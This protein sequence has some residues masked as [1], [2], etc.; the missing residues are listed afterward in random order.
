MVIQMIL[1]T[2]SVITCMLFLAVGPAA[3]FPKIFGVDGE[4]EQGQVLVLDARGLADLPTLRVFITDHAVYSQASH[5]VE[6]VVLSRGG[7]SGPINIRA[8]FTGF[9]EGQTVYAIPSN[10]DPQN[11]A[12]EFG[13]PLVVGKPLVNGATFGNGQSF[14]VVLYGTGFT[15]Q[16]AL[17]AV[18]LA[19]SPVWE[20]AANRVAQDVLQWTSTSIRFRVVQGNLQS[21]SDVYAFVTDD[22]GDR[23]T[24]GY[25]IRFAKPSIMNVGLSADRITIQGTGFGPQGGGL[26][27]FDDFERGVNGGRV[28]DTAETDWLNWH[29]GAVYTN[30]SSYSGAL[31]AYAH[32]VPPQTE[33]FDTSYYR[34]DPSGKVFISYMLSYLAPGNASTLGGVIKMSRINTNHPQASAYHGVGVVGMGSAKAAWPSDTECY[35]R[36]GITNTD[37]YI[38]GFPSPDGSWARVEMLNQLGNAGIPNGRVRWSMKGQQR[39]DFTFMNRGP[40]ETFQLVTSIMG[41]MGSAITQELHWHID[42]YYIATTLARVLITDVP[43]YDPAREYA[44]Q[45]VLSWSDNSIETGIKAGHMGNLAGKYLIVID[46][47]DN[48]S[49]GFQIPGQDNVAP[50]APAGLRMEQ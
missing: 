23:N 32:V 21:G 15:Q 50:A 13:E 36:I 35:Y 16:Q 46:S 4:P 14:E 5:V 28:S 42:D 41:L 2:C 26:I 8:D 49:Y 45:P 17:A 40:G 6:Q 19:D 38:P 11:E 9:S 1:R 3:A 29:D 39:E 48:R 20:Q 25:R 22:D 34:F 33:M 47:Q 27:V 7:P 43:A 44:I 37:G 31:S 10:G 24:L 12:A 18:T 30:R